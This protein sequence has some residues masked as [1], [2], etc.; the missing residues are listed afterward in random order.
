MFPFA[1]EYPS[2]SVSWLVD[3]IKNGT[4]MQNKAKALEHL[5]TVLAFVANWV[6]D[7]TEVPVVG[8][9]STDDCCEFI[10]LSG[11]EVP[12]DTV[13]T[14]GIFSNFLIEQLKAAVLKWI[15]E[16][17]ANPEAF[18]KAVKELLEMLFNK[19]G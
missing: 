6:D 16:L 12:A 10:R 4:L 5:F 15:M 13:S 14:N 1:K 18:A 2:E 19:E 7:I 8:T 17:I 3:A 11:F 9:S